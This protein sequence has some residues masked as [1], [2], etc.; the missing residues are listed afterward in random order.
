MSM[1]SFD[2]NIDIGRAEIILVGCGGTG[3]EVAKILCRTLY[4]MREAGLNIPKTITFVDPDIIEEK[5]VGRQAFAPQDVGRY[6]AEV[7]STR[8]NAVFGFGITFKAEP[9][10]PEE[11]YSHTYSH[12]II[13]G[14]VDSYLGRR[15]IAKAQNAIWIDSGN[16]RTAGQVIVGNSNDWKRVNNQFK[17]GTTEI[18][19]LPNASLVYP[20]LLEPEEQDTVPAIVG[21]EPSCAELMAQNAQHLLVNQQMA[22]IT[23]QYLYK[24]FFRQQIYTS[25]TTVN[26]DTLTMR[27]KLITASDYIQE[28]SA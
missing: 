26:I 10:I 20:E 1:I 5:N 9:F 14:A 3:S 25:M 23:G 12:S 18:H 28:E 13:L 27:S 4:H 11:N 7:L 19:Y 24:L 21:P 2:P 17:D 22:L 15:A 16:H 8:F 6:K